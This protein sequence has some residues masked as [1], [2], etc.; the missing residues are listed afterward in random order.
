MTRAAG[1]QLDL[2]DVRP[3]LL[4]GGR[5][6]ASVDLP[7]EARLLATDDGRTAFDSLGL[8]HAKLL[9]LCLDGLPVAE[10]AGR[11]DL[12]LPVARVLLGD[13]VEQDLVAVDLPG[14]VDGDRPDLDLL[15]RVLDGLQNL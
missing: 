4:T 13:L 2:L 15:E 6:T 1:Q 7:L 8:E 9:R 5:T 12:P 3:Y 11:I 10:L 14:A